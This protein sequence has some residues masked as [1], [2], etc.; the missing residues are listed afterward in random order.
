MIDLGECVESKNKDWG[1]KEKN[2]LLLSITHLFRHSIN[3]FG[4]Y[5][6]AYFEVSAEHMGINRL[7]HYSMKATKQLMVT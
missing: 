3:S 2:S 4:C 6:M 1:L 5:S 7:R